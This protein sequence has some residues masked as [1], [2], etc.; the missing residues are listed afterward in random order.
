MVQNMG[1]LVCI[2]KCHRANIKIIEVFLCK[3]WEI[4]LYYALPPITPLLSIPYNHKIRLCLSSMGR[5]GLTGSSWRWTGPAARH[6][7]E[8]FSLQGSWL[9]QL[10]DA[11]HRWR[12]PEQNAPV[13]PCMGKYRKHLCF[14]ASAYGFQKGMYGQATVKALGLVGGRE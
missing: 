9:R 3:H 10:G 8:T 7:P 5:A 2:L 13:V 14:I 12:T 1:G 4:C 11:L 6:Q